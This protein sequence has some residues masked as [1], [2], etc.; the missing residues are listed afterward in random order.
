[1]T[2]RGNPENGEST[3]ENSPSGPDI[4]V[5]GVTLG[6][7]NRPILQDLDFE[8]KKGEIVTILGGSG[9]GKS[10]LLKGLIGLLTPTRGTISLCGRDI[11]GA[12]AEQALFE[13]RRRIGVLFQQGALL[14]SLT[15][16]ENVALPIEEFTRLPVSIIE[17]ITQLKLE[18]VGLGDFAHFMPSDLSGGMRKRAALARALALDP[19]ILFCDEPSAGLDPVTSADLDQL[20]LEVNRSLGIT[21]VVVTHELASIEKISQRCIMLDREAHGIIAVGSPDQLK[22]GHPDPRV[23]A[24]FQRLPTKRTETDSEEEE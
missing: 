7:E 16:A 6:Y 5:R 17:D 12:D 18:M 8:I 4:E 14:G 1:M 20:L 2:M 21:M 23:Q 15:V 19:D 9:C 10:T 24:F 3:R 13:M 22:A 11:T